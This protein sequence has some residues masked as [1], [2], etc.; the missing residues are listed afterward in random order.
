MSYFA[1]E[2]CKLIAN[3]YC[4]PTTT[5]GLN[6]VFIE[7]GFAM[8]SYHFLKDL[9]ALRAEFELIEFA[10]SYTLP[11]DKETKPYNYIK[12]NYQDKTLFIEEFKCS[13]AEYASERN[14]AAKRMMRRIVADYIVKIEA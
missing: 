6:L 14:E 1:V 7:G 10:Q 13:K 3:F 5:F 12:L 4:K 11:N 2:C 8:D 9:I